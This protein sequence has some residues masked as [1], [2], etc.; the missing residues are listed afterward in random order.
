MSVNS[1]TP[2]WVADGEDTRRLSRWQPAE[3]RHDHLDHE[4]AAGLEVG[5]GIAEAGH[6]LVLRREVHDRVE[7][8]VHEA[9]PTVDGRRR[10]VADRHAD[11]VGS[12]L[13]PELVDH[14]RGE[15]DAVDGNAPRRERQR[16]PPGADTELERGPVS[17]ELG[18]GVDG[19]AEDLGGEHGRGR[20]VVPRR[21]RSV[22]LIGR[23]TRL[24]RPRSSPPAELPH[25]RRASGHDALVRPARVTADEAAAFL[26]SLHGGAVGDLEVLTGGYWS[27]AFGYQW[28]GRDLVA[29]FGQLRDGF[30]ADRAAMSYAG[31][32]LPV[33]EVLDIGEAFGGAYAIS[34]RHHGRFLEDVGPEDAQAVGATITRLLAALRAVPDDGRRPGSWR[35]WLLAGFVDDP[36]HTVNGWRPTIASDPAVDAVF[37]QCESRVARLVDACP[38]RRDLLH[39]DLLHGNVLVNSDATRVTAVFSWKCSMRGDFLFDT[40]WCT[41]WSRWHPGIAAADVWTRVTADVGGRDAATLVDA[42]VRHHCYEL[43]IGATHLGWHAWTG[44]RAGLDRVAETLRELLERGPLTA[45]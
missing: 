9:V 34:V 44:D 20:R 41:F 1:S 15:L 37:R 8:E 32:D 42:A 31:A 25:A 11:V 29:R 10:E 40:A 43:Q 14:G 21:D 3:R 36:G 4:R 19:G 22:E 45:A 16:D 6:L 7:H 27:S 33:P 2:A 13:R 39:G 26:A 35:G 28:N 5:G 30:E 17:G 24:S 23:H 18:Q 38:E 12:R